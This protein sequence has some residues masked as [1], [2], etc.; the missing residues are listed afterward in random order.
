MSWLCSCNLLNVNANTHCADNRCR[1]DRTSISIEEDSYDILLKEI[2]RDREYKSLG[3]G[4][5]EYGY[6]SGERSEP[7]TPQEELFSQLF[8]HEKILVKDMEV[9]ELRAHREQLAKIAFEARARLTAVDDEENGRKKN[10]SGKP[11]GFSRSVNTDETTTNAINAVKDR[12]KRL[13][14]NERIEAGLIAMGIDPKHA[15][16]LMTAGA[17]LGRMKEK[18]RIIVNN[19]KDKSLLTEDK[20]EEKP[21]FNPFAKKE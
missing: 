4:Y 15:A 1:K 6:L 18:D 16:Q 10:S 17:V 2:K 21:I 7:V 9:L 8:N 5:I 20:K 14:K 12:Q 13:T 11:T 3:F 19:D